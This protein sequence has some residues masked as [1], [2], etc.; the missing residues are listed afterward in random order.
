MPWFSMCLQIG[1]KYRSKV[2]NTMKLNPKTVLHRGVL[3][4]A[5]SYIYGCLG[6]NMGLCIITVSKQFIQGQKAL[7]IFTLSCIS[8][9]TKL[10]A[11]PLLYQYA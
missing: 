3:C 5:L 7:Q 4:N 6:Q 10:A 9:L 8:V 11:F 2:S 1:E